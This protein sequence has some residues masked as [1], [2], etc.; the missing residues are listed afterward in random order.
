M[1]VYVHVNVS[2]DTLDLYSYLQYSL[3]CTCAYT[4]SEYDMNSFPCV[5]NMYA[6]FFLRLC[7]MYH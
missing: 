2:M 5:L 6:I 4:P 3:Q 7:L 1:N